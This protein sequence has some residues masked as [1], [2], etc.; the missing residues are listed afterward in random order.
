MSFTSSGGG[1]TGANERQDVDVLSMPA[2]TTV[3]TELP[4]AAALGD[5]TANPNTTS[6][7]AFSLIFNGASW[8]RARGDITNGID[9][10]VTR[11]S[12]G[13]GAVSL[14]KAEDAV[15]ADGDVGV[16]SLAVRNDNIA[17]AFSGANGDYTPI[18]VTAQGEVFTVG[19]RAEDV[20]HV[21][22][23]RGIFVLSVRNDTATTV[24]SDTNLDY[25]PL[26]TSS[27]G[28]LWMVHKVK[29]TAAL[30]P[31]LFTDFG[32]NAALNV[33]ATAGNVLS[34]SCH[35]ENAAERYI[36][37]HNTAGVPAGAA[38]P[39]YSFLVPSNQQTIIGTDFFTNEGANFSTGIGF[40]FST[41]KD[42]N[43][44]GAAA[45]QSVI[46]HFV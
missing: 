29:P 30:A 17:T 43:T 18:A 5:A 9:V 36:Q 33:K 23:D 22:G 11:V 4:A 28:E 38:V 34:I 24:L 40:A 21:S 31:T 3:D 16:M 12:P 37:L 35:N 26:A 44:A 19:S 32:A 13:T 7:G 46:I 14:G 6:V 27:A 15:H 8:D 39:L 1:T 41:T 25:T 2:S 42:V 20:G 10:D 45:D